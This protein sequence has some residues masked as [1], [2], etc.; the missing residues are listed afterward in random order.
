MQPYACIYIH[1]AL[2][3]RT[4]T[5]L[6]GPRCSCRLAMQSLCMSGGLETL[7]SGWLT[8]HA[9][10]SRYAAVVVGNSGAR[11]RQAVARIAVL[12]ACVVMFLALQCGLA[13]WYQ[14]QLNDLCRPVGA[15]TCCIQTRLLPH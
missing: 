3:A 13:T 15:Q 4:H 5:Q 7:R 12:A 1:S 8:S 2:L 10:A 6:L 9:S 14:Q 11:R